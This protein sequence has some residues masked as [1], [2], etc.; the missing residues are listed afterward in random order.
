CRMALVE[1]P[2]PPTARHASEELDKDPLILGFALL[3]HNVQLHGITADSC[4]L[5]HMR[6]PVIAPSG[7]GADRHFTTSAS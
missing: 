5:T 1:S 7:T 2:V 6:L 3:T 4:V